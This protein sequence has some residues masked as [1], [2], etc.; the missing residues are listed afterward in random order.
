MS[1]TTVDLR[2]LPSSLTLMTVKH[3]IVPTCDALSVGTNDRWKQ[4]PAG[5]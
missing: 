4:A 2:S 3:V 5:W 1:K